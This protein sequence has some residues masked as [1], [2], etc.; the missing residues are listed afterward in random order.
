MVA[1]HYASEITRQ[2]VGYD[3]VLYNRGR[4]LINQQL[5]QI[6]INTLLVSN[7]R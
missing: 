4:I 6:L 3:N 5:G 2:A 1:Q 7:Y